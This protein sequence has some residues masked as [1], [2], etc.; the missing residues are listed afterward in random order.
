MYAVM[1]V[2]CEACGTKDRMLGSVVNTTIEADEVAYNFMSQ[3]DYG[4]YCAVTLVVTIEP[5]IE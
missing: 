4:D 2:G 3:A 5:V 1:I